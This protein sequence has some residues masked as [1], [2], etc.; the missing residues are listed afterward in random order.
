MAARNREKTRLLGDTPD[1]AVET[2]GAPVN[3]D[4]DVD[5]LGPAERLPGEMESAMR[6]GVGDDEGNESIRERVPND[7][8]PEEA[9]R[10]LKTPAPS[11]KRGKR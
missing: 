3:P 2:A 5:T 8:T 7:L 11:E 4:R 9:R 6:T 10:V 1:D